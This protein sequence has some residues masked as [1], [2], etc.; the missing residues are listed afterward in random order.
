MAT[1]TTPPIRPVESFAPT[2]E[3]RAPVVQPQQ[4][5]LAGLLAL[6]IAVFSLLGGNFFSLDNLF[7]IQRLGVELGLLA[8]AMTPVIVTGGID[9]SVGSLMALSAVLMGMMWRDAGVPIWL[10]AGIAVLIAALAGGLNAL[11]I[12]RLRIPPLIVTLGS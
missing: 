7:E 11:L 6:E 3:R 9:L 8:L 12:T 5:V 4:L 10:A 1:L 2:R